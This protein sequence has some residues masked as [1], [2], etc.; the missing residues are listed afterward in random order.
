MDPCRVSKVGAGSADPDPGGFN[1]LDKLE[2]ACPWALCHHDTFRQRA[3]R[4]TV[5]ISRQQAIFYSPSRSGKKRDRDPDAHDSFLGLAKPSGAAILRHCH[6][7][8]SSQHISRCPRR[9]TTMSFRCQD[10]AMSSAAPRARPRRIARRASTARGRH[11]RR[12]GWSTAPAPPSW[13]IV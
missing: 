4:C 7:S 1:P 8:A 12:P 9:A 6:A 3:A 11:H 5:Q 10:R 2:T 13:G